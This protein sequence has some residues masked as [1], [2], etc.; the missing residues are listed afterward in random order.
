MP[1]LTNNTN[2]LDALNQL[3]QALKEINKG[4]I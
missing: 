3:I 1:G 2:T 4:R